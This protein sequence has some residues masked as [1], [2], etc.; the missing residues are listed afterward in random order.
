MMVISVRDDGGD[1]ETKD[2]VVRV[3]VLET[4]LKGI[5]KSLR[6][7]CSVIRLRKMDL[8]DGDVN[9]RDK[10]LEFLDDPRL[11]EVVTK[12]IEKDEM[13][14]GEALIARRYLMCALMFKHSQRQGAVVN[15]RLCEVRRAIF[16]KT[17]AGREVYIYKV[18]L[19][20]IFHLQ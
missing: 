13:E 18:C 17:K 19:I 6:K 10:V 9:D 12:Y 1:G 2:L 16:H 20:C 7:E 4:K 14:D 8:Y 15:L 11:L 3:K 5:M